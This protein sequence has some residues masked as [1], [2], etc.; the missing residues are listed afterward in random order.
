QSSLD[1]PSLLAGRKFDFTPR[2]APMHSKSAHL[3]KHLHLHLVPGRA[4]QQGGFG[5]E[6]KPS[7]GIREASPRGCTRRTGCVSSRPWG[8]SPI[9]AEIIFVDLG[10][11]MATLPP[12]TCRPSGT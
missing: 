2:L 7:R 5:V 4:R 9:L 12:P 11:R 8:Q 6:K 3:I 1:R 10:T